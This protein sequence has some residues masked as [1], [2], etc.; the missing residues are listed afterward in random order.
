MA[1]NNIGNMILG[2]GLSN[3]ASST[4]E[5]DGEVQGLHELQLSIEDITKDYYKKSQK[6]FE[7]IE[8]YLKIIATGGGDTNHLNFDLA[9]LT[10]EKEDD[11]KDEAKKSA[12]DKKSAGKLKNTI[13]LDDLIKYNDSAAATGVILHSDFQELFKTIKK[14]DNK[15]KGGLGELFGDFA[16]GALG[17]V[18][19]AGALVAFA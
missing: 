1:D 12:Q 7:D 2:D 6:T 5:I 3:I 16:K 9:S 17:L 19:L 15:K 14:D 18:V 11:T 8:E 13:K 10:G 4:D